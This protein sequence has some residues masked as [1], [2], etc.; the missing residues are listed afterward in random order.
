MPKA[1][2]FGL[3]QT[4][5]V[6]DGD[7]ACPQKLSSRTVIAAAVADGRSCGATCGCGTTSCSNGATLE[8]FSAANCAT[9]VRKV[10]A[11]GSCTNIG[12]AL[13]GASY[14]YTA[15]SG[16][17]VTTQAAVLGSVTYTAPRTL[18]CTIF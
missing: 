6:H 12:N 10:N 5:I 9:S 7:V 17:N 4:C 14:R 2:G 16:C 8:A 15:G 18:C 11:D 1:S 3:V 13:T